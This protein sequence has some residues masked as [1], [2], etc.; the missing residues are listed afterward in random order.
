MALPLKDVSERLY[1]A[2]EFE[3]LPEFWEGYELVEGRLVKKPMAGYEHNWIV[4]VIKYA[5]YQLDPGR[6]L[7]IM[8]SET[9]TTIGPKDTPMPDI[10][11]WTAKTRPKQLIKGAAPRPDLAVEIMSPRDLETKKRRTEAKEKIKRYQAAGVRLAWLIDP[12]AK[13]VEVYQPDQ[14]IPVRLLTV[15]D[16]LEG[17]D[18]IPGFSLSVAALFEYNLQEEEI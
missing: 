17:E 13:T 5:Y 11:F 2:E 15:N 16:Q 8:M 1:T 10:S 9:S 4:E 12:E 18:I 14:E 3:Y 6:K 7:G